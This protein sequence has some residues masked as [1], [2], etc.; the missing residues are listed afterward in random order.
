MVIVILTAKGVSSHCDCVL[1]NGGNFRGERQYE[2]SHLSLEDNSPYAELGCSFR[3]FN[4]SKHSGRCF[5]C[6]KSAVVTSASLLVT[7]A[8]L[9]VTMFYLKHLFLIASCYY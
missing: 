2:T 3:C 6:L 7:S 4:A 8:L 9:V 1:I 5:R